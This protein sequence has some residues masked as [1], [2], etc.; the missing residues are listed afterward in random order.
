[1]I[2][3][4]KCLAITTGGN[5]RDVSPAWQVFLAN[6]SASD[7]IEDREA[8]QRFPWLD[9]KWDSESDWSTL[10]ECMLMSLQI[11]R[12]C[13]RLLW[14]WTQCTMESSDYCNH[15]HNWWAPARSLC[16]CEA[17]LSECEQQAFMHL[18]SSA[19]KWL[20]RA[21]AS[22]AIIRTQLREAE[23]N[24]RLVCRW[25]K[26]SSCT[27]IDFTLYNEV[28]SAKKRLNDD[29]ISLH[30]DTRLTSSQSR[31]AKILL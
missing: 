7:L 23:L 1:M 20:S 22:C 14:L 6:S 24:Q 12:R 26:N 13:A 17:R 28:L 15:L 29:R 4:E 30:W 19:F 9:V 8:F 16:E 11:E 21:S 10:R 5:C 18:I 27:P 25:N 2:S 31:T 3:E